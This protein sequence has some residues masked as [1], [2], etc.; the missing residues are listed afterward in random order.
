M[1]PPSY[2]GLASDLVGSVTPSHIRRT[3][4]RCSELIAAASNMSDINFA[5]GDSRFRTACLSFSHRSHSFQNP[6]SG[7]SGESSRHESDR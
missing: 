7:S 3:I 1:K 4:S 2:N 5:C 6:R